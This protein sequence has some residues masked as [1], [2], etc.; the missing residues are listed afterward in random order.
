VTALCNGG[1]SRPNPQIG[2]LVSFTS[3][4]IEAFLAKYVSRS[5]AQA[6]A[7]VIV[8]TTY[9]ASV[10]CASDPPPDPGLTMD[11]V[12]HILSPKDPLNFFPAVQRVQDWFTRIF[13]CAAC[14]CVDGTRPNC[15]TP[16]APSGLDVNPQL[17]SGTVGNECWDAS[18]AFVS[19]P[20]TNTPT[21]SVDMNSLLPGNTLVSVTPWHGGG[22]AHAKPLPAT[23]HQILVGTV[24]QGSGVGPTGYLAFFN[25]SGTLAAQAVPVIDFSSPPYDNPQT[26]IPF[27]VPANSASWQFELVSTFRA[28]GNSQLVNWT[29]TPDLSYTCTASPNT[30]STPCCPPDPLLEQKLEEILQLLAQL[31]L[32]PPS[33]PSSWTDGQRHPNLS[34]AGTVTLAG[35][36]IGVRAE[37]RV[38]PTGVQIDP[39]SPTFYWDAG[40]ITPIAVGSP[41]RGGR[42]VF[43]PQSY[44]LPDFTDQ[45]GYTLKHGTVIDLVEL[46]PV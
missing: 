13:W 19:P 36:P 40:F 43:N 5:I 8:G 23:P 11:D 41:L 10:L 3:S 39:G 30:P 6:M 37:M 34:N 26:I 46:L 4:A 42:L 45:I 16:S 21:D 12:L 20:A 18:A 15:G 28:G 27:E 17:P 25:A 14:Q 1:D 24:G 9:E 32:S 38:P 2:T 29:V 22:L 33:G 31:H 35:S 7:V 44:T